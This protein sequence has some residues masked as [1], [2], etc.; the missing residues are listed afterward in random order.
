M[1]A[2]SFL[3]CKPHSASL[4][5]CSFVVMDN[6]FI[7]KDTCTGTFLLE[8]SENKIPLISSNMAYWRT[9]LKYSSKSNWGTGVKNLSYPETQYCSTQI[10]GC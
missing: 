1:P 5:L 9:A 4:Q 3:P 8:D 7:C 10:L 2:P 6:I